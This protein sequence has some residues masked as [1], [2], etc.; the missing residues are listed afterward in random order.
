MSTVDESRGE[1]L[2][3]PIGHYTGR[4][5]RSVAPVTYEHTVMLGARVLRL[6]DP[7]LAVWLL[8]RGSRDRTRPVT[9]T[10]R[11]V[12]AEA[13]AVGVPDP[14]RVLAGLI[15]DGLLAETIPETEHS[16]EFAASYRLAPLMLGLG[17]TAEE[18]WEHRIGFSGQP[19]VKVAGVHYG[20]W[21]W[22]HLDGDL[23]SGCRAHADTAIRAG[24]TDP[25]QTVPE[26][27]LTDFFTVLHPVLTSGA[28]CLD[29][30]RLPEPA[31]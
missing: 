31:R 12:L 19:A 15:A 1:P 3:F 9:W 21:E 20:L 28:A 10:R 4:L 13:A 26:R 30:S 6:G 29:L 2:I 8:A 11:R 25:D 24:V 23:W 14:A 5:H 16:V 7:Q 22:S 27:I 18:P 17:N